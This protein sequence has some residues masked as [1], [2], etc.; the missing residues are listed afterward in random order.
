MKIRLLIVLSLFVFQ[1]SFANTIT[2]V[3]PVA[4]TLQPLTYCDPNN[5]G[6][7]TFDFA[8]L[9][10]VIL[11]A[12]SSAASNYVVGYYSTS[13]DAQTGANPISS[14]YNNVNP[15]NQTIYFRVTNINTNAF[16]VGSLQLVVNPTPDVTVPTDISMCDSNNDGF[17]A[18]D[19]TSL[20]PQL[21]GVNN[22]A[23]IT[24]TFHTSLLNANLGSSPITPISN[25]V[26]ANG[27]V[28]WARVAVNATGCYKVVSFHLYVT[29]IPQ[30]MQPNYPE[31]ALCDSTGAVGYEVFDLNSRVP[32]ILM[33]QTGMYVTFHTSLA[34]AQ[35]STNPIVN[36]SAYVNSSIYVQTLAIRITN[37]VTGCYTISTM[38]IVVKP[39]PHL[40]P[41]TSPYTVCDADQD[42]IATFDLTSMAGDLNQG[43]TIPYI[44][45]FYE[46]FTDAVIG[47]NEITSPYV[48]I[49]PFVQNIYVRAEDQITHCYS[50]ISIQLEVNPA[51]LA[52]TL[53]WLTACDTDANPQDGITTVDLTQKTAAIFSVQPLPASNY[54]VTF[55]TSQ[56]LAN[57]GIS[58]IIPVTNYTGSS[59]QT[60]W[61]R[62]EN[63]ATHCY[64]VGNFQLIISG[65]FA[66]TT[67]TPLQVCDSD[68]NPND[69]YTTFDLNVKSTEINQFHPVYLVTYYPSYMDAVN[70]TNQI[71]NPTA[72]TNVTPAVQT[73]GVRVTVPTGCVTL[74][75]LDIRVLP[76]PTPN[77]NPPALVSQCDVNN[78]G[79][80]MEMFDLTLNAAYIVNGDPNLTL[81]Y[82]ATM[83]DAQFNL[84]E[85]LT[86][87][88]AL[89]G[90]NVWIRVENSYADYLGNH[91]YVLV[92]QPLRVYSLPNPIITTATGFNTVYV[93]ASNTVVQSLL[94]DSGVIGNYSYQWYLNG[95]LIAG[96]TNSTYSV[97]SATPNNESRAYSVS[98]ENASVSGCSAMSLGF[99]VLQSNGVP[100]PTGLVSQSFA[101]GAT[102]ANI[103]INGTNVQWYATATNKMTT[104]TPLPLNTPLV[105]G[106]TYYATQT[107]GG[108]ES[109][110]R[111]PV[112]VHITLGV[113][114]NE[115]FPIRFAPNPVKDILTLQ[116]SVVLKSVTVYT[117]LGQKVFEQKVDGTAITIDL[118]RLTTGNY[119]VKVQGETG[120]KTL[121]IIKE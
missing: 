114:D 71:T 51:P 74:S 4:P 78:S 5:D 35:S 31:Y 108:I 40:T 32:S 58:P 13:T 88:A 49:N 29:P 83:A 102:L 91:C 119:I 99:V 93:D 80:M 84:N 41:P 33:G 62:V 26:A 54:T 18:F 50:V 100:P 97:N 53:S 46:T 69:Q 43:N 103:V 115:I 1:C 42:G 85:I 9:N 7:G 6:F 3:D 37:A 92:E 87:V 22:P 113:T 81:H 110:A 57:A 75:T 117:M 61:Y 38:D 89:V 120:Q 107:V 66:V 34:D 96:A 56:V 98:V 21:V 111:L 10:Y 20:V 55:Y 45:T 67:P 8:D 63:S 86:P 39:L 109:V 59:G 16:T 36:P 79:D 65:P 19:L 44:I 76:V 90:S 121:R 82:F 11:A 28:I 118:S 25:Y 2:A 72:Y 47:G 14:P 77:T 70:N 23:T 68:A 30:S 60:I 17:E 95:T 104:S 52:Y 64:N 24:V 48:N 15:W 73:L 105:D 12:Q 112:T 27:T 106:T 101:P 116:S 94:L